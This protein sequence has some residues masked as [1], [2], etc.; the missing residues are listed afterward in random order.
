MYV[1][2]ICNQKKKKGLVIW[3]SHNNITG[4]IFFFGIFG[5]LLS[6][7]DRINKDRSVVV[8]C[9]NV[10]ENFFSKVKY[11]ALGNQEIKPRMWNLP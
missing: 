1:C 3:L 9:E 2:S 7:I 4:R 5:H 8:A 10:V 11:S 6:L